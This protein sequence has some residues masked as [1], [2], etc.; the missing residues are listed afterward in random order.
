MMRQDIREDTSGDVGQFLEMINFVKLD[1]SFSIAS[2]AK[3][4]VAIYGG[5]VQQDGSSL[6]LYNIQYNLIEAK[7]HFKVLFNNSRLWTLGTNILLATG[8]SLSVIPF[9]IAEEQLLHI[10]GSKRDAHDHPPVQNDMI[11]EDSDALNLIEFKE[12]MP[13]TTF[14]IPPRERPITEEEFDEMVET[15][16]STHTVNVYERKVPKGEA[17]PRC[18][19]VINEDP[20]EGLSMPL[21]LLAKA[22]EHQGYSEMEIT[23]ELVPQLIIHGATPD[24]MRVLRKYTT[25]SESVLVDCTHNAIRTDNKALLARCLTIDFEEEYMV[26][27]LRKKLAIEDVIYLV[28]FLYE[29]LSGKCACPEIHDMDLCEVVLKWLASV[30]DAHYTNILMSK[31]KRMAKLFAKWRDLIEKHIESLQQLSSFSPLIERMA[32]AKETKVATSSKWYNIE[33]IRI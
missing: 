30:V 29:C 24:L 16:V 12:S 14:N 25:L 19:L 33:V 6:M 9:Y 8:Q 15:L 7:Q 11:D 10:I 26:Y 4:Y 22:M 21:E 5:N 1:E 32:L 13:L 20:E 2:P 31:S 18:T 23:N 3:N 27:S 17:A 28:Q